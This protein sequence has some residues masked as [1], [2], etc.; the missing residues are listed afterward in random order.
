LPIVGGQATSAFCAA[1]KP[2]TLSKGHRLYIEVGEANGE[3][4]LKMVLKPTILLKAR[5]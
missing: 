3:R 1:F 5:K 4:S 2:F